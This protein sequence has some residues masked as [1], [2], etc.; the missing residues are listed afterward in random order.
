MIDMRILTLNMNMFNLQIDDSF[1]SFLEKYNPDVAIIQEFR[2]TKITDIK[3]Y[4]PIK[5][6]QYEEADEIDGRHRI[7]MALCKEN[8]WTPVKNQELKNYGYRYVN[9]IDKN[10]DWSVLGVHI[11]VDKKRMMKH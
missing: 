10:N 11:P 9:I 6:N 1:Y 3:N 2:Y 7:T 4:F 5:P 8:S